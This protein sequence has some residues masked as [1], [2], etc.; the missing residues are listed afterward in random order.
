MSKRTGT[1]RDRAEPPFRQCVSHTGQRLQNQ[2]EHERC[3]TVLVQLRMML[4]TNKQRGSGGTGASEEYRDGQLRE[5]TA[6]L[7]VSRVRHSPQ[8]SRTE[9][10]A[11]N[12]VSGL[13]PLSPVFLWESRSDP[14]SEE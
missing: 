6:S 1:A 4:T 14:R 2:A 9:V 10:W 12:P 7:S 11:S 3:Y 13:D 5:H 8:P